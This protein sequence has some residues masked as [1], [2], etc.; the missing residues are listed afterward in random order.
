[1]V[2]GGVEDIDFALL[3][4]RGIRALVLD[5]DHTLVKYNTTILDSKTRDFLLAQKQAGLI[6]QICIAS[7]SRRDLSAIAESIGAQ[8]LRVG[9]FIK[10]PSSTY[11]K[12]LLREL[13][14]P[15][16]EV[17]MVGDK[18]LTD[19]L[20]GNRA[21]LVTVLVNPIGPDRL[22]DRLIMRRLWGRWYVR[23]F[24]NLER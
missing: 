23:R 3:H 15:P 6:D 12:L 1:M 21:G 10:K 5:V 4:R 22:F 8:T 16:Y 19:I 13:K 7:N 20:G 24:S 2:V 14:R 11:F 9:R 18:L 17:V